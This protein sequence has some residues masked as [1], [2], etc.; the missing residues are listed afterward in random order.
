MYPVE[1]RED[2]GGD[3]VEWHLTS[4]R[5]RGGTQVKS[6]GQVRAALPP[7]FVE[8]LAALFPQAV[9]EKILA[10]YGQERPTTLRGNRLKTSIRDLMTE[11]GEAAVKFDRVLWYPE[12]LII[13]NVREKELSGLPAY[14]EG[15]LYLQSLSSMVPALVLAPEP[16][17][18]VLDV[19]AAPGS[20][21]TQLAA[22]MQNR[23]HLLANDLNPLRVER[24][25]Y[26]LRVQGVSI[27]EVSQEDGRHLG[28]LY[29]EAFD[30]VLLDAPCSG[31]GLFDADSPATYRQ[32]SPANVRKLASLQ[33]KLFNAA[34]QALRPGGTLVYSTCTLA[35]EENELVVA[36]ALEEFAGRLETAA[37]PLALP[38]ATPALTE[39]DGR[40]LPP[41]IRQAFRILPSRTFEGFFVCRFR[42]L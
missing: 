2:T 42:K 1:Q 8:R 28:R 30:R 26:N 41:S 9:Q 32:W 17:E 25:K 18:R 7:A 3:G 33:R 15:R 29:P 35:P 22:L 6:I 14:Q 36:W 10:G 20:K 11:L 4:G 5:S 34:F 24:L 38:E 31:E 39:I 40:T 27:A 21:T 37:S 13:K 23:G 12:A 16:G 19:S